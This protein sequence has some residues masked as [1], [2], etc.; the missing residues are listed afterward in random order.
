MFGLIQKSLTP[1][2]VKRASFLM[3][4]YAGVIFISTTWFALQTDFS[5]REEL[6]RGLVRVAGM[7]G[8]AFWLLTLDKKAWW[9][10]IAACGFLAVLGVV[11]ILTLGFA[12]VA[13]DTS[14][15]WVVLNVA[16]PVYLL[17]HTTLLLAKRETRRVFG[18]SKA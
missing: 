8:L 1:V 14:L 2:P 15:L 11:G 12:G 5:H 16:V 18:V 10:S 3:L 6:F 9:L 17:G 13:Y 7:T 4:L